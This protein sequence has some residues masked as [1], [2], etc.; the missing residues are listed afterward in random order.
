[1]EKSGSMSAKAKLAVVSKELARFSKLVAGH[2]RL[3]EAIGAL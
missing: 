2:R 1:M 3:L